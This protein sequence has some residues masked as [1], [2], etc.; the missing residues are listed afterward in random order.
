MLLLV[1]VACNSSCCCFSCWYFHKLNILSMLNVNTRRKML[2]GSLC[3]L[4]HLFFCYFVHASVGVSMCILC[5]CV[6][7]NVILGA[8][9]TC[10]FLSL[11]LSFSS[12][13]FSS[14]LMSTCDSLLW[15]MNLCLRVTMANS[16][17][18]NNWYWYSCIACVFTFLFSFPLSPS[19]LLLHFYLIIL[20]LATCVLPLSVCVCFH[21]NT[22]QLPPRGKCFWWKL[23]F[24]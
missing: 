18:S 6:Y 17:P 2:S 4:T 16:V 20:T 12:Y 11:T 10:L 7:V 23:N 13:F 15:N 8:S 24:D 1:I 14:F 21:F 3:V 19:S 9:H 5:A 22:T